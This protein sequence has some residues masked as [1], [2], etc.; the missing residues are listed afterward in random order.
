MDYLTRIA[1]FVCELSVDDLDEATRT[2]TKNVVLDTL[3]AILAGSRLAENACLARFAAERASKRS[4][5]VI[6]HPLGADPMLATLTNGTAGVA[7]EVDEGNRWGGGHPGIHV[8]PA[9]L[10]TAEELAA[11][12]SHF[13]EAVVAG[14]EVVSRLGGATQLPPNVH[15][16]GT[17]GTIGAA[18]AVAK[19][20]GYDAAGVREVANLAASMSPANSWAPCLEGATIRNLYAGR[21]GLQAILAVHLHRCGYTGVVDAP[22]EI[23]GTI[24]G[25]AFDSDAVVEGL[26]TQYRIRQNYFKFHACCLYN[27]PTLDALTAITATSRFTAEQVDKVEVTTIPLAERMTDPAPKTMLGAKFSIPYAVGAALVLGK[28]DVS[29]F[30][31]EAREDPRIQELAARVAVDVDPR[32]SLRSSKRPISRVTVTLKDGQSLSHEVTTVRG[33]AENP[34][35]RCELDDK[36]LSLAGPVLGDTGAHAVVATV[37]RLEGL[38]DIGE[39][40]T[41]LA[42][43]GEKVH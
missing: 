11:P 42:G 5:T 7:L 43:C 21:S 33:D 38:G 14:Y 20:H 23:F 24:L 39:L 19:L 26:G 17:W 6:G 35:P 41:L 34:A 16:H 37:D 2:A 25:Q 15:P 4:A 10:A 12:P 40:T 3:G 27:H 36:F 32:M 28:T 1:R 8:V 9:S 18:V 29:A 30:E 13:L 31:K 22:S